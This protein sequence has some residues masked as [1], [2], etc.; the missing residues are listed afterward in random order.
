MERLP[1]RSEAHN[2]TML[3]EF[4]TEE[5]KSGDSKATIGNKRLHV[6]GG[7]ECWKI[8]R[9]ETSLVFFFS[10]H[11]TTPAQCRISLRVELFQVLMG[12][13]L[14]QDGADQQLFHCLFIPTFALVC[15]SSLNPHQGFVSSSRCPE[16][17]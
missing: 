1:L 17:I 12:T 10:S 7:E 3:I 15:P 6:T 2:K 11:Y 13:G 9:G 5:W 8:K 4:I 14:W 16:A